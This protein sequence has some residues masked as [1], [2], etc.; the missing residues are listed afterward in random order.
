MFR[1]R[2]SKEGRSIR[3]IGHAV[4]EILASI[5]PAAAEGYVFPG[6]A[7]GN[8][9]IGSRR[10]EGPLLG[11]QGSQML[12]RTS[13]ATVASTA[14]DLGFTE[15]MIASMLGHSRGTMTSRCPS[16]RRR[17]GQCGR[18]CRIAHPVDVVSSQFKQSRGFRA[19]TQ[20]R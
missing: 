15:A 3:P 2:D 19:H 4:F 1:L 7:E 17:F 8:P 14:N 16:Y 11:A 6:T 13:C 12:R 10:Y 9:F 18:R 20:L 5:R